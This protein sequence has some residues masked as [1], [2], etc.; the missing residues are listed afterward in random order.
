MF[1]CDWLLSIKLAMNN[2]D[3]TL[4]SQNKISF[5]QSGQLNTWVNGLL[6]SPGQGN[7]SSV[8]EILCRAVLWIQIMSDNYSHSSGTRHNFSQGEH[9]K[10]HKVND[11]SFVICRQINMADKIRLVF[12]LYCLFWVLMHLHNLLMLLWRPIF[13]T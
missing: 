4:R 8:S 13:V 12:S 6:Y 7:S 3:K 2:D 11:K 10:F 9:R 1:T 5:C